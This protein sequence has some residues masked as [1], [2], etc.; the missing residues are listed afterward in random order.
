LHF[1]SSDSASVSASGSTSIAP[2]YYFGPNAQGEII[3]SRATSSVKFNVDNVNLLFSHAFPKG[4]YAQ[5]SAYAGLGS[6]YLKQAITNTY[7]GDQDAN[8]DPNPFTNTVYNT[9]KYIGIGPKLGIA[10]TG[11]LTN[12]FSIVAELAS[13]LMVGS[14]KSK[15][16]FK[17]QG[18]DNPTPAHTALSDISQIKI[19]P[20]I[21]SNIALSYH[22]AFKKGSYLTTQLGYMYRLYVDGINQVVPSELVPNQFRNGVIALISST[23]VQSNL[24]LSGPYIKVSWVC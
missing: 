18:L 12:E 24:D 17:T 13:T 20:E 16:N 7:S 1:N 23:Q 22:K 5:F 10:A 14:M 21:A 9:S 11:L 3:G 4:H 19:V 6:A 2:P 8:D 15:T